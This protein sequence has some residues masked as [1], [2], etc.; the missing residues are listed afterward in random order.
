MINS[1]YEKIDILELWI[2]G[3]HTQFPNKN[4]KWLF[5]EGSG[6]HT[7][8][9]VVNDDRASFFEYYLNLVQNV[10]TINYIT[11]PDAKTNTYLHTDKDNPNYKDLGDLVPIFRSSSEVMIA[12]NRSNF[13][14][15]NP[16]TWIERVDIYQLENNEDKPRWNLIKS[17]IPNGYV[18]FYDGYYKVEVKTK[19]PTVRPTD[20]EG[21]RVHLRRLQVYRTGA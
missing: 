4:K 20:P 10:P 18:Q 21:R 8:A 11:T 17:D 15:N 12:F 9:F 2:D 1:N 6:Y 16:E 5:R 13:E 7:V 19:L 3:R 14:I